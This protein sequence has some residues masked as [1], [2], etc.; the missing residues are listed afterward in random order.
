MSDNVYIIGVGMIKF[1]KYLQTGIKE[2]TGMVLD[3]LFKDSG[4]TRENI[5]AAWFSNAYWGLFSDQHGIRGQVALSANGIQGVSVI[6]VE[7]ACASG[8]TALHGA[9]MSV[10]SGLHDCVLAIG[11]EKLYNEDRQK[12]INSFIAST[13]VENT[14]R[15]IAGWIEE[16]KKKREQEARNKGTQAAEVKT[17]DHSVFMEFYAY[18]SRM[19]MEK[20]GT[21]QK[22][23]AIIAAKSHNNSALNPL[24]QYTFTTTVEQVLN[25]RLIAYPLTRSMCAP[26]GDGAAAAIVCSEAFLKQNPTSRA[27]KIRASVLEGGRRTGVKDVGA[28]ASKRAFSMAGLGPEDI[29]LMEVHDASAFGEISATEAIGM[30]KPGEGGIIAEKGDTAL[31][32]RIPVNTSGGLVSRGHP[33]GASGLAQIHEL[34]MQLRGEAGARQVKKHKIALAENGGGTLGLDEAA[35]GLHI[36]EKP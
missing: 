15:M 24:A 9:W 30:C 33:L 26:I 35:M 11:V 25:D 19:H 23:I 2:L 32:G 10:K 4:L 3:P 13:D 8:S 28:R 5:Q 17:L 22:Q 21:T 12:S 16:E 20:Y 36:L 29:D 31:T 6:N 34:V 7:N 1:G 14:R 18:D 27:I